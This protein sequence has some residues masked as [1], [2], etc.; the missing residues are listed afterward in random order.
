[1]EGRLFRT[2]TQGRAIGRSALGLAFMPAFPRLDLVVAPLAVMLA[3][4]IAGMFVALAGALGTASIANAATAPIPFNGFVPPHEQSRGLS[5]IDYGSRVI[6]FTG[7][8]ILPVPN[9]ASWQRATSD[10]TVYD[11]ATR[12]QVDYR[13]ILIPGR[14]IR[15]II[16]GLD[17]HAG[18][19]FLVCRNGE[20]SNRCV[21]YSVV[22][23]D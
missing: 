20:G 16:V 13:D 15:A 7:E 21:R 11:T 5:T 8:A 3:V 12:N 4:M 19:D 14:G 9:A 1:M 6:T 2:G 10:Y 17:G 23:A 22:R 18:R